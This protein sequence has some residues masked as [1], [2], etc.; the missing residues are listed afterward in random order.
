MVSGDAGAADW[1]VV[2]RVTG[3]RGVRASMLPPGSRLL[4]WRQLGPGE[5]AWD[6]DRHNL[7]HGEE[8]AA[9]LIYGPGEERSIDAGTPG[10]GVPNARRPPAAAGHLRLRSWPARALPRPAR[11]GRGGHGF[12]L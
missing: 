7:P 2:L 8:V 11:P 1:T 12:P 6:V 3:G 9:V 4:S 10:E 5:V